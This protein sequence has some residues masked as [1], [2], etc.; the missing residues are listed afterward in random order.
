MVDNLTINKEYESLVPP[1]PRQE[2]EE[3]KESIKINGLY[4]QVITNADGVILDGHHRFKASKELNLEIIPIVK[5]FNDPLDEK[6]FVIECNLRRRHL[7][8]HERA[9]LVDKLH[10]IEAEQAR[11]RQIELAATRATTDAGKLKHLIEHSIDKSR[12]R[13]NLRPPKRK[14]DRHKTKERNRNESRQKA[15]K[16]MHLSD[17]TLRK[18]QKIKA[19]DPELFKEVDLGWLTI[20]KAY[21]TLQR[22]KERKRLEEEAKSLPLMDTNNSAIIPLVGHTDLE[23]YYPTMKENS[24]DLIFTDPQYDRDSLPIYSVLGKAAQR[25][26]K[27]GG[28]L[29]CYVGTYALP[30]ILRYLEDAGLSFWWQIIVKHTGAAARMHKQ[31][32][33]VKQKPLVWFVNGNK[34]NA[35]E[36]IGDYIES[37]PPD[38]VRHKWQQSTVEAEYVI[39]HLTVENQLVMDPFAGSGT[40]ALAALKLNRRFITFD[41]DANTA[42]LANQRLMEFINDRELV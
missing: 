28:S 39:K 30:E 26:L 41:K 2:F 10:E 22:K 25:V 19:E 13:N 7:Q 31:K 32:V 21:K 40:T 1:L 15:A 14:G 3:L 37:T 5:T 16:V 20:G 36:D 42:V 9:K 12:L 33:W 4:Q 17:E 6:R 29:V 18:Y 8:I 34:S 27:P 24:V 38:K 11:K 35:P 23:T